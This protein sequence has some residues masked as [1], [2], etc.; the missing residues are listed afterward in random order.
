MGSDPAARGAELLPDA[1][2]RLPTARVP[3]V[4]HDG[5]LR[6]VHRDR[7]AVSNELALQATNPVLLPHTRDPDE[8]WLPE[9]GAVMLVGF[10]DFKGPADV[11]RP[12]PAVIRAVDRVGAF[13]GM[14]GLT[15]VPARSHVA[16]VTILRTPPSLFA[17]IWF[18]RRV[19]L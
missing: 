3:A 13:C 5:S 14:D 1:V 12:L 2:Q 16:T 9:Q 11:E 4:T 19:I 17:G 15:A 18:V 7:V 6:D 10:V 8:I